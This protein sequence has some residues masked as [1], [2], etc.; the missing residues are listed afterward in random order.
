MQH[1]LFDIENH[2]QILSF[3]LIPFR[4]AEK[5]STAKNAKKN[6]NFFALFAFFAVKI[7]VVCS[8]QEIHIGAGF[9]AG[10]FV[11]L[12]TNQRGRKHGLHF[13]FVWDMA[14]ADDVQGCHQQT[15]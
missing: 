10:Q 15:N 2:S 5:L 13:A 7:F 1:A 9:S 11:E 12:G 4:E 14:E 8:K 6:K 3:F